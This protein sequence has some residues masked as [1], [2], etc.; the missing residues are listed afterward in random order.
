[1]TRSPITQS[2]ALL[3]AALSTGRTGAAL[4]RVSP[5]VA[6]GD[7]PHRTRSSRGSMLLELGCGIA[8]MTA[9][10]LAPRVRRYVCTDHLCG[11]RQLRQ[12]LAAKARRGAS[13]G[14]KDTEQRG[15]QD[16]GG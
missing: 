2:T 11:L 6:G 9:M 16:A 13:G 10:A 12:N 7:A 5:L 8:G 1:M 15:G 4:R 14:W 3:H